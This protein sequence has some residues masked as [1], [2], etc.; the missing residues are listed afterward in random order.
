MQVRHF[1]FYSHILGRD[2][3]V[4]VTGYWGFPVI[5]FPTTFGSYVQNSDFGLTASVAHLVN[6]GVVKLYNIQTIDSD[7]F[8]AKNLTDCQKIFNYHQYMRF[9]RE[10]FLPYVQADSNNHR[11][12]V[13]GCSFGGYHAANVAFRF[14]DVTAYLISM[15]GAF[16]IRNFVDQCPDDRVYFNCPIEFMRNEE[17]WRY[18]HMGIILGTSDW[19]I[20]KDKNQQMSGILNAKGIDHWYDEKKWAKH[21]WPLWCMVFPEYLNA[22]FK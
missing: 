16:S 17:S 10:E 13:A 18:H 11:V 4:E 2:I 14:P 8:Y 6:S 7:T 15:S 5:M 12:A 3:M 1:P 9:Y 19:D 21:D 20:C 22:C